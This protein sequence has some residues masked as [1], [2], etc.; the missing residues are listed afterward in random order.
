V[1]TILKYAV[2]G[3]AAALLAAEC[4]LI[5]AQAD[6]LAP[7]GGPLVT[8]AQQHAAAAQLAVRQGVTPGT[9][10]AGPDV[11]GQAVAAGAGLAPAG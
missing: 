2:L 5:P 10:H 3:A 11:F 8:A 9:G 6:A 7:P 4:A 1:R